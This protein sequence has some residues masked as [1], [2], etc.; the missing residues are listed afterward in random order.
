MDSI[1]IIYEETSSVL[2]LTLMLMLMGEITSDLAVFPDL[3]R[4]SNWKL[5]SPTT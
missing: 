4:I 3:Q 5:L 1:G 2:T